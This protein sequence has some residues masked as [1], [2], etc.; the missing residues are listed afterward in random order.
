MP[1]SFSKNPVVVFAAG[2]VGA[3]II[4]FIVFGLIDN[5][6]LLARVAHIIVSGALFVA[7]DRAVAARDPLQRLKV[8]VLPNS[9]AE[10]DSD[11]MRHY[12]RFIATC[13]VGCSS[14]FAHFSAWDD[15]PMYVVMLATRYNVATCFAAG[16]FGRALA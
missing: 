12:F 9:A 7:L 11:S 5:W 8:H 1:S 6:H 13:I 15:G 14:V 10:N 2:S 3:A 4:L 16:L